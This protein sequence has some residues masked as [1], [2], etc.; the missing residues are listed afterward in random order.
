MPNHDSISGH[1]QLHCLFNRLYRRTATKCSKPRT[2]GLCEKNPPQDDI[3]QSGGNIADE[4]PVKL[5]K[6]LLQFIQLNFVSFDDF[7]ID[8][9]SLGCDWL[10]VIIGLDNGLAPHRRQAII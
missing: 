1:R 9:R 10:W 3:G 4:L 8:V 5:P 6:I 2:T 7:A